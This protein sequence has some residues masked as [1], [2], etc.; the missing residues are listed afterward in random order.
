MGNRGNDIIRAWLNQ[1]ASR[2]ILGSI[3]VNVE[4]W[5]R[6][7]RIR[8][9][10]IDPPE[11]GGSERVGEILS[12]LEIFLLE[13]GTEFQSLIASGADHLEKYLERSFR[14]YLLDRSRSLQTDPWRFFYRA[15]SEI[16]RESEKF[17]HQLRSGRFFMFSMKIPSLAR[18]PLR[19]EEIERISFPLSVHP[20][21]NEL[22]AAKALLPLAAHFWREACLIRGEDLWLDLR[23][24]VNWVFRHVPSPR[25]V[26]LSADYESSASDAGVPGVERT[27]E[28]ASEAFPF[29][30]DIPRL[31]SCF[32][33]RLTWEERRIFYDRRVCELDWGA[34]ASRMGYAGP[35][36]PLYRY[37]QVETKLKR[38]LRDQEMLGP[39]DFT[40]QEWEFFCEALR[41]ILKNVFSPP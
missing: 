28:P 7:R 5:L 26:S 16:L 8:P 11:L 19:E 21:L 31:A 29:A 34:I 1:P 4:R 17:H 38:F 41:Q 32:V 40:P 24:F 18:P 13:H 20:Q 30:C 15:S 12:E 37:G 33:N 25:E 39:E 10:A 3:A 27:A 9:A 36:G 23:D 14:N 2:R 22:L 6:R 35:S